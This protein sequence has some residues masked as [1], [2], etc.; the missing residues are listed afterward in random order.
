MCKLV[1]C[2]F[3]FVVS[4]LCSGQGS[5]RMGLPHTLLF[6][7]VYQCKCNSKCNAKC[8]CNVKCLS[9]YT[10]CNA[11]GNPLQCKICILVMPGMHSGTQIPNCL[12]FVLCISVCRTLV[13]QPVLQWVCSIFISKQVEYKQNIGTSSRPCIV[14]NFTRM[15]VPPLGEES[16]STLL[17]LELSWVSW[18][19]ST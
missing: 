2:G 5:Q 17:E 18:R 3:L 13:S 11:K 19:S 8:K 4:C 1:Q 14:F 9:V 15:I 10:V 12:F 6:S 7:R 16:G